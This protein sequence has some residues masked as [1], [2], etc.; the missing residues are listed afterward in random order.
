MP[1]DLLT[2]LKRRAIPCSARFLAFKMNSM[3]PTS[4]MQFLQFLMQVNVSSKSY[5]YSN[6]DT[7]LDQQYPNARMAS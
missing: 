4:G 5:K 3:Q 6:T 1:A 2:E 7:L